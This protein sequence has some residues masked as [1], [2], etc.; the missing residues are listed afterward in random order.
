[1][2]MINTMAIRSIWVTV[3]LVPRKGKQDKLQRGVTTYNPDRGE[4]Q[5]DFNARSFRHNRRDDDVAVELGTNAHAN[6]AE[7]HDKQWPEAP[8]PENL[9]EVANRPGA[10]AVHSPQIVVVDDGVVALERLGARGDPFVQAGPGTFLAG[11]ERAIRQ[12]PQER[13]AQD[14]SH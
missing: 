12:P 5:A 2:G 13:K 4:K 7:V 6:D 14:D 8:I 9:Q 1:M 10:G 3:S 11:R